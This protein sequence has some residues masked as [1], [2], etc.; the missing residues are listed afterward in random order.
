MKA[1][2]GVLVS[3]AVDSTYEVMNGLSGMQRN[4]I[5]RLCCLPQIGNDEV[6]TLI[7]TCQQHYVWKKH[8]FF[9]S[10]RPQNLSMVMIS[11]PNGGDYDITHA[12]K[13]R[14][15]VV[16][17]R[18]NTFASV[19]LNRTVSKGCYR[20]TVCMESGDNSLLFGSCPSDRVHKF[21]SNMIG[22]ERRNSPHGYG[23]GTGGSCSFQFV[24]A[25]L[26]RLRGWAVTDHCVPDVEKK[27]PTTSEKS[28]ALEVDVSKRT[29][30][31]FVAGKKV[32]YDFS[33]VNCPLHLG[34]SGYHTPSFT[35]VSFARL[36]APTLSWVVCTHHPCLPKS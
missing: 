13:S 27:I 17:T 28:V 26:V 11:N 31:L 3:I 2:V 5:L 30:S 33:E 16:F 25:S 36:V 22:L 6:R 1:G 9:L 35:S 24:N 18:F 34:M 20:W 15:N 12:E 4:V 7:G 29:L 32:P 10:A 14:L 19:F 23:A 21:Y 8:P